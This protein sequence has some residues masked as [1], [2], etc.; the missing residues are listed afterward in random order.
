MYFGSLAVFFGGVTLLIGNCVKRFQL[1]FV[2]SRTRE[3][4][5]RHCKARVAYV[6]KASSTNNGELHLAPFAA[7]QLWSAARDATALFIRC[8]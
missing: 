5:H 4:S 6:K 8:S 1:S 3:L 2:S 7:S